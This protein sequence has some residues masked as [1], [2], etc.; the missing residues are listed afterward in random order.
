M[1]QQ[2][3]RGMTGKLK[4][5]VLIVGLFALIAVVTIVLSTG[6]QIL[7]GRTNPSVAAA[8]QATTARTEAK[9]SEGEARARRYPGQ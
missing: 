2:P 4:L 8:D 1:T 5:T 7:Q 6:V 3:P 9:T